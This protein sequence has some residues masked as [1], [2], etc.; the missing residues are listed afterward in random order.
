MSASWPAGQ[1]CT[2]QAR[3]SAVERRASIPYSSRMRGAWSGE[4]PNSATSSA[5]YRLYNIG[6]HQPVELLRFIEMLER[7]LGKPA[8]K[9]L[10]PMQ[11]GDVPATYADVQ[12]LV[13]DVG[14]KPD[15]PL[16]EGI[17]KFVEWYRGYYGC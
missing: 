7:A 2:R 11:P 13:D 16:E 10:L 1:K 14:F 9:N 4:T 15:T 8:K 12:D 5:P 6:N 17:K 3:R